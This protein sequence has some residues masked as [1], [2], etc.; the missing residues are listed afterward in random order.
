LAGS[1]TKVIARVD[2]VHSVAMGD[3]VRL[4]VKMHLAHF[5]DPVSGAPLR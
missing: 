1:G 5:F 3:G 4:A 2:G